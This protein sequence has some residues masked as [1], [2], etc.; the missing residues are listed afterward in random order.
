MPHPPDHPA[1]SGRPQA[2]TGKVVSAEEA[3]RLIRDGDTLAT[4]GFIGSGFAEGLAKALE[5]RF[6]ETGRPRD[7]TLVYAAGQGDGKDKGLNHLGHEGL[8]KRVIGGHWGLV[9][10][11][12]ALALDN[13]IEAYN[14]PQGVVAHLFRA[15]AAGRPGLLTHVGL[16]TFVDPDFDGGKINA[17]TTEDLVER[18]TLRGRDYLFYPTFPIHAALL[19]GTTADLDGNVTQ[20]DEALYLEGLQIAQAVH[21]S[22]G[23]VIVQVARIAERGTLHPRQVRI[24]GIMVDCVVQA[25]PEDH[26]Q[27]F[28]DRLNPAFTGAVKVPLKSLPPMP[29]DARKVIARRAAFELRPN[30]VVNLGIG[31]PEGVANIAAEESINDLL[32]LTTEP[33]AIGGV[34][35][36][37]LNFGASTNM[38]ALVDQPTQFDFY[39]GGGL[40]IAFL[41]LAQADGE[42]NVNVSRF[43]RRL[44]GAGGFINISQNAKKVVFVGTLTAGKPQLTIGDGR[45]EIVAEDGSRKF[46]AAVEQR[47][48]SGPLAAASGRPI[49]YVTERCVFRLRPEGLELIEIAPGLDLQRDVLAHLAFTPLMPRPPAVMD[50]RIF[51]PEAMGLRD[52][53]LSQPI[54]DRLSYDPDENLFFVN[55][56]GYTVKSLEQ[57]DHIRD[58]IER[59]L[60]AIGRRVYAIVNYENFEIYPDVV[61]AYTAMVRDLVERRYSGVSRYTTSAFLRMLLGDKLKGRDQSPHIYWNQQ[62]ARAHLGE[63]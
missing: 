12:G 21:N 24:P 5:R 6:L 11:L 44:A 51:R 2:R 56:E 20:E 33:G 7:L 17:R 27:S 38:A 53:L 15:I 25:D 16:G 59:R 32:T 52:D 10:K 4:T 14:F 50:S 13:K 18:T 40:D 60:D 61:D 30:A 19:R 57:I 35:A 22:G 46:L 9:P 48:F 42:G 28:T 43:G 58:V 49:L 8:V 26:W 1:L 39:D 23:V 31:M 36:G 63:K 45:L 47:T 62:E 54:E 41:G 29:L 3:M 34:P 37:G 55:F